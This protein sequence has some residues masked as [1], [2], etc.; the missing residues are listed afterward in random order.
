MVDAHPSRRM[1]LALLLAGGAGLP[2]LAVAN[3]EPFTPRPRPSSN[4]P[5]ISYATWNDDEPAYRFFPGEEIEVAVLSAPEL[6]KTAVVQPDGR[7]SLPL[8]APIMAADRS[9]AEVQA[10]ISQA[11]APQLLRPDVVVSVH[12][13]APLKVFVG[14]EVNNPGVF[15]MQGDLDALRAVMVA[16]GFRSTAR[17]N[18]VVIIRRGRNGQ[19]MMRTVNLLQVLSDPAHADLVPLRRFDI[20][21]VPRTRVSEAGMFIQQWFRDLS[22]VTF[23]FSYAVG[24]TV[25]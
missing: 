13:T 14:G 4:F 3:T 11:Y 10:A 19:A 6:N 1:V 7:I 2:G 16:G 15:D 25:P 21:Y 12:S 5:N 22:P 17:R 8:L 20:V 9:V 23:G 24:N 18:E